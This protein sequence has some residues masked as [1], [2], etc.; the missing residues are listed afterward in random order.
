MITLKATGL[1]PAAFKNWL[2]LKNNMRITENAA[3]TLIEY[4]QL[5]QR[6][7]SATEFDILEIMFILR[8]LVWNCFKCSCMLCEV[9]YEVLRNKTRQ[10]IIGFGGAFTDSA[11]INIASLPLAAQ[12]KLLQS[13]F[14]Q[15]GWSFLNSVHV[16]VKFVCVFVCVCVCVWERERERERDYVFMSTGVYA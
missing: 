16:D 15:E 10:T 4:N 3:Q 11:G 7:S 5:V 1:D 9:V 8:S 13:Y 14:A 2:P 12:Q 6:N